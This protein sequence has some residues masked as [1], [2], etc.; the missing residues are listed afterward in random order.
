MPKSEYRDDFLIAVAL[1]EFSVQYVQ[2]DPELAEHAWQLAAAR[3][4][5]RDSR[6]AMA[7]DEL[8]IGASRE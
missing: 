1:T 7:V 8:E 2:A 6:P 3:L 4:I 5:D